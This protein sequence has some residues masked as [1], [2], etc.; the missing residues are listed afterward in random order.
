V[1]VRVWECVLESVAVGLGRE[2]ARVLLVGPTCGE[3]GPSIGS[4]LVGWWVVERGIYEAAIIRKKQK[5]GWADAAHNNEL[6]V[7]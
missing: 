5:E 6:G 2:R 7:L 4:E 1:C 3:Q